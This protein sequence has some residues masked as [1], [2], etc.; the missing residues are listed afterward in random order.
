MKKVFTLIF[1]FLTVCLLLVSCNKS[2]APRGMKLASDTSKVYY[3]LYVPQGWVIDSSTSNITSAHVSK[4]DRT[5]L[6][7]Q[8]QGNKTIDVWWTGYKSSVNATFEDFVIETENED[9]I[10]G[11][12]NGKRYVFTVSFGDDS[13][14]KYELIAV[15]KGEILYALTFSYYG[16]TKDGK[17]TYSDATNSEDIKKIKDNFKFNDT[18][19]ESSEPMYEAKNAPEG[20]KCAS[21]A[22]I[23]DYYLFVPSAWTVEKTSGTISSAYVSEIDKTNVSVMQWNVSSYD[24]TAWWDGEYI[25]QLYNAFDPKAINKDENG[26]VS[27]SPSEIITIKETALDC[28]LG[29]NDAKKYTYSVKIGED[30]YDYQVIALMARASIYVMTFTYKN[31]C[32]MS[33]Y[34]SDV[35]KII[36][37]F[38]FS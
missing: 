37:N 21:N 31:G 4:F 34:N 12:I 23:V 33:V 17:T 15:V 14:L 11:G 25:N 7:I 9:I 18:L 10:I 24:Y 28:K 22:K 1:T 38:R 26:K 13:D 8:A 20:M 16:T 27:Y 32:D 19:T 36:S 35:E 5:S 2:D 30:V 6:N 3:S 29:E